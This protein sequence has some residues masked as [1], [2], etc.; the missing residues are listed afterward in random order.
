[1]SLSTRHAEPDAVDAAHLTPRRTA[2]SVATAVRTLDR[3]QHAEVRHTG[4]RVLPPLDR[5]QS[6]QWSRPWWLNTAWRVAKIARS[7]GLSG[8][9]PMFHGC[10]Q[11]G[12]RSSGRS[13]IR[14][15]A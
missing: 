14:P 2:P 13:P 5:S 7:T 1:M 9:W 8:L 6:N 3:R 4:I 10:T 12:R 11:I 15:G